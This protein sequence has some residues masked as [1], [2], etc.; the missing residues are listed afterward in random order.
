[1]SAERVTSGSHR[2]EHIQSTISILHCDERRASIC[3]ILKSYER[4]PGGPLSNPKSTFVQSCN[5]KVDQDV[6]K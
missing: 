5:S 6:V 3:R 4:F 2:L 1:M